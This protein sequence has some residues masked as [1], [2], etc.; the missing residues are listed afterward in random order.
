MAGRRRRPGARPGEHRR[1]QPRRRRDRYGEATGITQTLRNFGASIGLAVLG[2]IL[3]M[4]NTVEHREL[5]RGARRAEGARRRDRRLALAVGRW[6]ARSGGFGEAT[7]RAAQRAFEAVQHDFADSTQTIFYVMAGIMVVTFI[8]AH[9]WLPK[10][11]VEAIVE[12][13]DDATAPAE[14]G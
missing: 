9:F 13:S 3:I 4:Q 10:D 2:T 8:V 12:P 6:R 14:S 11:R 5:A 1:A 7:G